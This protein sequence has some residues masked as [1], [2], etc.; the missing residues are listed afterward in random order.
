MTQPAVFSA[1]AA[2]C[3]A[4]AAGINAYIG[5]QNRND[6]LDKQVYDSLTKKADESNSLVI[7]NNHQIP[8]ETGKSGDVSRIYTLIQ[9]SMKD[10]DRLNKRYGLLL[11]VDKIKRKNIK[12][13]DEFKNYFFDLLHSSIW[14][15]LK[16]QGAEK[17]YS[18]KILNEQIQDIKKFYKSQ[19]YSK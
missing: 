1:I 10:I 18:S 3:A 2:T 12:K 16:E 4:V 7:K 6:A 5:Y 11:N 9:H 8:L 15:D 17:T 13:K 14:I 19:I